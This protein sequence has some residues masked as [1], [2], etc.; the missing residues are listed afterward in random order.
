MT[1][2][3]AAVKKKHRLRKVVLLFCLLVL[4]GAGLWYARP[5]GLTVLFPGM[6]PEI[7]DVTLI[8]FGDDQRMETRN[9]QLSADDAGFDALLSRVEALRFHRPP[10]NLVLQAVPALSDRFAPAK[11]VEDDDIEHV[12]ITLAQSVS[13]DPRY[14]QVT[15]YIDE[16]S[17]RDFEHNV[18]LPLIMPKGKEI[19]QALARDFWEIA[20]PIDS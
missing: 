14:A 5:V 19:G 17:Y 6:E 11:P 15:F 9:I 16:W 3:E 1:T 8:H 13:E 4:L 12:Y 2:G 10:T 20:A 18:S 7:I